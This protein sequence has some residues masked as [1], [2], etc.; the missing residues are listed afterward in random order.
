ML[1]QLILRI[2]R[3]RLQAID[4][5]GPTTRFTGS[6]LGDA[7]GAA[8]DRG[9]NFRAAPGNA[10]QSDRVRSYHRES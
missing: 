2:Y 1:I 3:W 9:G 6:N 5:G 4:A 8:Q 10:I 7:L